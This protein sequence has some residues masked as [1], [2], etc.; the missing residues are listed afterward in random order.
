MF[1]Q[2]H[3]NSTPRLASRRESLSLSLSLERKRKQQR[4]RESKEPAAS[5]YKP[6]WSQPEGGQAEDGC[7]KVGKRERKKERKKALVPWDLHATL[8]ES[9]VGDWLFFHFF[10]FSLSFFLLLLGVGFFFFSFFSFLSFLLSIYPLHL[11]PFRLAFLSSLAFFL[12][13]SLLPTTASSPR[14]T[15]FS[16]SCQLTPLLCITKRSTPA[17]TPFAS[18][19]SPPFLAP[20]STLDIPATPLW[21][22][23]GVCVCQDCQAGYG[24]EY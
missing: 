15:S 14:F 3:I 18:R 23:C 22:W 9:H 12:L 1:A 20:F 24:K 2:I 10:F 8:C 11:S 16:F 17:I 13:P 4:E 21:F 5:K 7:G 6:L 19:Q